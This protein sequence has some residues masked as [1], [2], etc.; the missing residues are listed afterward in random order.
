M[1]M[2]NSISLIKYLDKSNNDDEQ[3]IVDE[4]DNI[5]IEEWFG[6]MWEVCIKPG[7]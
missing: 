3:L 5:Y 7:A 1:W 4:H 2:R 6:L